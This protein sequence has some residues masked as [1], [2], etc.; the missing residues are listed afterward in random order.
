MKL[1]QVR[2]LKVEIDKDV[3][4]D[5]EFQIFHLH[6]GGW[7]GLDS[8]DVLS[9]AVVQSLDRSLK[10]QVAYHSTSSQ[11]A[12]FSFS[13][14]DVV[15]VL[16]FSTSPQLG[17][18]KIYRKK[19]E[20]IVERAKNA[21]RVAHNPLTF[22]LAKDEFYR[23]LSAALNLPKIVDELDVEVNES[24][25]S[26]LLAVLAFDI[27]Y[28]K[29]VNDTY[30]H[31]YGDQ[32][33]KTFAMRL[34]ATAQEIELEAQGKVR[35]VLGHPSGEEFLAYISGGCSRE[36][37]LVWAEQFRSKI[38]DEILPNAKEWSD[39]SKRDDLTV[40]QLPP[41]QERGVK[42]SIGVA[43][44]ST[45]TTAE[46]LS[47][48]TKFLLDRADTAL[49][50]A[51]AG[52]RNQVVEFDDILDSRG[53]VLEHDRTTHVV[54]V[55]IGANVGV[56]TGQEFRVFS[57]TFSGAKKFHLNDGRTTR[58]LG[59]YPRVELTRIT[60][61]NVQPEI[62]FAFISNE[63]EKHIEIDVGAHL[64]AIP[65]GSIGNIATHRSK[66]F[67]SV[68]DAKSRD[69]AS[70]LKSYLEEQTSSHKK[71]FSVV[72][73]FVNDQEYLKKYGS[74]AVNAALT[75]IYR[76]I[77]ALVRPVGKI[78]SLDSVTIGIVGLQQWYD[79]NVIKNL[80]NEFHSDFP[81]LSLVAGVFNNDDLE[82][83]GKKDIKLNPVN[84]VE[85]A[86]LAASQFGRDV[87][88]GV[89]H[90]DH[91]VAVRL[92]K[93]QIETQSYTSG[94]A[95]FERLLELGVINSTLLNLGGLMYSGA[96]N[97]KKAAEQYEAALALSPE[98]STYKTNL[99][100]VLRF[101]GEKERALKIFN[102]LTK[103]QVD[104]ALKKGLS[105]MI[106]YAA[107]LAGVHK[108]GISNFDVEKFKHVASG[109]MNYEEKLKESKKHDYALILT[110][111]NEIEI[112]KNRLD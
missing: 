41:Q 43:F 104:N 51:K 58:T 1:E 65:V 101:L 48:E 93:A 14:L 85:F 62:S 28:F 82:S 47:D 7:V 59:V 68:L 71:V 100:I 86:Q 73:R 15:I 26:N 99:G 81:E 94:Q 72:F 40:L 29:Q 109:V 96:G 112:A 38:A 46:S 70:S 75:Q 9:A 97:K 23:K 78:A 76:D 3:G 44:Q 24:A 67:T 8:P 19:L 88:L 77:L 91:K 102:S 56:V 79:E 66:Y 6:N 52:G 2:F 4:S 64:E 108:E 27:D 60:T 30:G 31:L 49:Y 42:A 103:D 83:S 22:L 90:F 74:A 33:L 87:E 11:D 36:E 39:L 106:G 50:R 20:L 13:E 80:V 25:N 35:I 89:T 57:P 18:R 5:V 17:K 45:S 84:S 63:S 54:A 69:D 10:E 95:D 21:F 107:L 55:D 105:A 53:R 98:V 37:V 16:K 111:L 110:V 34:E 61:F 12:W 32:V 92:L